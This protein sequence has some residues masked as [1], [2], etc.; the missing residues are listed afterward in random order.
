MYVKWNFI[1][2]GEREQSILQAIQLLS[3]CER[4][5]TLRQ[6]I[7]RRAPGI[8]SDKLDFICE[9]VNTNRR[10]F[11]KATSDIDKFMNL[12]TR[13]TIITEGSYSF[14]EVLPLYGNFQSPYF[15]KAGDQR[16]A[17]D[18]NLDSSVSAAA[19]KIRVGM[20]NKHFSATY[21]LIIYLA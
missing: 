14:S 4:K 7:L 9:S 10:Y 2:I 21:S 19:V 12:V 17:K 1:F 3:E 16:H 13:E 18:G 15:E 6:A 5:E 20:D 11:I 8:S